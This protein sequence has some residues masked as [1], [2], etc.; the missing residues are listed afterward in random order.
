MSRALEVAASVPKAR[1]INKNTLETAMTTP[2]S[3]AARSWK[4]EY[5]DRASQIKLT[6]RGVWILDSGQW[7]KEYLS[8]ELPDA[9]SGTANLL[10]RSRSM[11]RLAMSGMSGR[12]LLVDVAERKETGNRQKSG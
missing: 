8:S 1:R 4:G 12:W 9:T 6:L 10:R 11:R 7:S 2:I 3:A 5:C